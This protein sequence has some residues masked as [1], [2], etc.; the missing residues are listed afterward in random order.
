M[1]I[2]SKIKC[3]Q[4]IFNDGSHARVGSEVRLKN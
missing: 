1:V 4:K 3:Q 2:N